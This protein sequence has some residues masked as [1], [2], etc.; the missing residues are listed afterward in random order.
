MKQIVILFL[1]FSLFSCKSTNKEKENLDEKIPKAEKKYFSESQKKLDYYNLKAKEEFESGNNKQGLKYLKDSVKSAIVG[2][3]IDNYKFKKL[4]G[5]IFET[6]KSDKPIFLQVTATWCPPCKAEIP[7]LN[8]IVE[9]YSDS[10]DFV[11]LFRDTK[12]KL[13]EFA[14]QYDKKINIIPSPKKLERG[15]LEISG[16]R[17]KLGFPY[18]YLISKE[19][20]IQNF[21]GGAFAPNDKKTIEDVYKLNYDK[22]EKEI[23][24]L[25][26][27]GA[28]K[29]V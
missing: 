21:R 7:A 18:D 11:L 12:D 23:L 19:R 25:L 2:S 29:D 17:H 14:K 26:K 9:K 15:L 1:L 6:N 13:D 24:N 5:T 27:T 4:D 20:F 8:A 16:F 3:Y 28:N 10:M 22:L